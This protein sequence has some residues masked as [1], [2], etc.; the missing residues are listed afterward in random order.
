MRWYHGGQAAWRIATCCLGKK[1]GGT[2]DMECVGL[3]M[4]KGNFSRSL[5]CFESLSLSKPIWEMGIV[6]VPNLEDHPKDYKKMRCCA[7]NTASS[8]DTWQV[9]EKT[10]EQSHGT[11]KICT[12]KK[13]C[14]KR[15][16]R[17]TMLTLCPLCEHF[18]HSSMP[19]KLPFFHE[20]MNFSPYWLQHKD[21]S[22]LSNKQRTNRSKISWAVFLDSHPAPNFQI[23]LIW[24]SWLFYN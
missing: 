24:Q 15:I 13:S 8:T 9:P 14:N 7:R 12:P 10:Q 22:S 2:T 23:T 5:S 20:W 16:K 17:N 1:E 6:T 3:E 19:H 4:H 18:S 21:K 11:E